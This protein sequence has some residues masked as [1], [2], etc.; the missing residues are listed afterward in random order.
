VEARWTKK[1]AETFNGYKDHVRTDADSKSGIKAS[2]RT[3]RTR[4]Q[5]KRWGVGN[6]ILEKGARGAELS[7]AQKAHNRQKS[8][9]RC[10]IEHIFGY[11]ENSMHGPELEY[12]G[13]ARI[14]TRIGLANLTYNLCRYVQLMRLGRVPAMA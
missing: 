5:L 3:A 8:K 9:T 1:G 2:G 13:L 11:I 14:S 4:A 10:L 6:Q 7:D 12:I